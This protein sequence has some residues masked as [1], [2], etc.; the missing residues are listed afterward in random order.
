V[1]GALVCDE[2]C[3]TTIGDRP[4]DKSRRRVE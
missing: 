3:A 1:F 2:L 4:K